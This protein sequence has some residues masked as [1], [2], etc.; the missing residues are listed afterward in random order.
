[1][2]ELSTLL[3]E[4]REGTLDKPGA[5]ELLK[6]VRD[7]S[8]LMKLMSVASEVRDECVGRTYKLEAFMSPI[9]KCTTNPPCKYCRRSAGTERELLTP[10]EIRWG[11]ERVAETGIKRLEIGGG[12]PWGGAGEAVINA[13]R[14]IKEVAPNLLIRVNVGPALTREN[15]LK[16]KELG[17]AEVSSNF[18]T[19]NREVFREVKPGDD[20]NARIALA[21]TIDAAGLRLSTTIMVGIGSTY[22]DYV[23][24]I[25]WLKENIR[26]LGRVAI[27][28]LRPIKGTPMESTPAGSVM[29]AL[30]VGALARAVLRDVDLGFG[31]IMNDHRLIPLRAMA[32]GNREVHLS[33]LVTKSR[34]WLRPSISPAE[35]KVITNGDLILI[36]YLPLITR[37][38]KEAGM[39]PEVEPPSTTSR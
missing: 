21:K 23:N 29:E 22:E 9:T 36:N 38:I 3:R 28:V 13:V 18:E 30:K 6:K 20:L 33:V 11:A 31:G 4:A 10:E 14:I 8:D 19:M 34:T 17:V 37:I 32:G 7:Y 16:L 35:T 26:N 12:T 1:M 39:E 5:L 15:L 24:H 27:T 2:S 25:F